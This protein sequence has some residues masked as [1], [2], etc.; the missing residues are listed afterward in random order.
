MLELNSWFF[1]LVLNFLVLL[2]VL[3]LVL[4]RPLLKV[5]DEREATVKG[6]LEAAGDMTAKKDAAL[7]DMKQSLSEASSE[8]RAAYDELRGQGAQSQKESLSKAASEAADMLE[9]ARKTLAAEAEQARGRLKA[10]V[11]KFSDEIVEKLVKV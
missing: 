8:A 1:V 7:I 6:S 10:D 5:F 3:N 9:E 11:Q 4:F 2:Y